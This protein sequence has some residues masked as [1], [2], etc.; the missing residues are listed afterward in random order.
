MGE[1]SIPVVLTF[2]SDDG[3]WQG[4][5]L[6]QILPVVAVTCAIMSF[7]FI[8]LSRWCLAIRKKKWRMPNQ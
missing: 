5:R 8:P 3:G 1:F 4:Q 7:A 6:A 2:T